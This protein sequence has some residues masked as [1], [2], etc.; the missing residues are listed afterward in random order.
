[1]IIRLFI[2]TIYQTD[3]SI[4]WHSCR[5][6]H[7][8]TISIHIRR[9]I[10]EPGIIQHSAG[11]GVCSIDADYD[12]VSYLLHHAEYCLEWILTLCIQFI[13]N[14]C[15]RKSTHDEW[16]EVHVDRCYSTGVFD[17]EIFQH[18]MVLH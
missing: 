8:I 7:R 1:M 14:D 5:N 11:G 18:R 6:E 13:S 2:Q 4:G 17:I 3:L 10:N 12:V 16:I 15:C 9:L